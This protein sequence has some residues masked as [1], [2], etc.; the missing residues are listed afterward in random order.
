MKARA[1]WLMCAVV[2]VVAAA[3]IKCIV[4]PGQSW[5]AEL[6]RDEALIK[7]GARQD[8]ADRLI[9]DGALV[10]RTRAEIVSMLGEPEPPGQVLGWDIVFY[11]GPTRA[12]LSCDFEWLVARF[13]SDGRVAETRIVRD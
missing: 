4:L 5:D 8:M 11:L 10:G 6:W 13:G 2:I 7:S 12:F 3:S 9:A 1:R